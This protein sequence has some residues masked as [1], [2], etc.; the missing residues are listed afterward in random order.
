MF[1]IKR[2]PKSLS[3]SSASLFK[4]NPEEFFLKYLAG[5]RPDRIPQQRP[6]AAGSAFDARVKS[7]LAADLGMTDNTYEVLFEAQVEP[8]NREWAAPAGVH[9][10]EEYKATGAY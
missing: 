7:S 5:N 1:A 8:Q 2:K 4:K 9:L 3:Y 10:L 6:A